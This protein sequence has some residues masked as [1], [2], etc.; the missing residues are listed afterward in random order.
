[1]SS[2]PKYRMRRRQLI[3][4]KE[5]SKLPP[6]TISKCLS[7][8][9]GE[10]WFQQSEGELTNGSAEE[11]QKNHPKRESNLCQCDHEVSY[12]GNTIIVLATPEAH[13]GL[14]ERSKHPHG[15]GVF[16]PHGLT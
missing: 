14:D 10:L 9:D 5:H 11:P 15:F 13:D 4:K 16:I 1:D 6:Q 7:G 2:A 3:F 12:H 8:D